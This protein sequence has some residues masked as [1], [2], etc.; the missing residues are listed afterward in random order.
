MTPPLTADAFSCGADS[1]FRPVFGAELLPAN[2]NAAT[3]FAIPAY[4]KGTIAYIDA[5]RSLGVQGVKIAAVYPILASDFPGSAGYLSYYKS[6]AA[7][8]RKRGMK[9]LV[10]IGCLFPGEFSDLKAPAAGRR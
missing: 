3:R 2:G 7:E 9:V 1:T 5:L 4:L 10:A 8:L 6:V